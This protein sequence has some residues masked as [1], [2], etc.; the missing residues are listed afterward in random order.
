MGKI[1]GQKCVVRIF[2]KDLAVGRKSSKTIITREQRREGMNPFQIFHISLRSTYDRKMGPKRLE[3]LGMFP[4][5]CKK[6]RNSLHAL[7]YYMID[8]D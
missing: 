5:K 1:P 6:T 3:H 8:L 7:S 4:R 2:S